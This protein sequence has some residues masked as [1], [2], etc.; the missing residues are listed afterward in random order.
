RKIALRQILTPE[1]RARLT[2]LKMV[3]PEL[4]TR[5]EDYLIQL[6]QAGRIRTPVTDEQLKRLLAALAARKRNI[7]IRRI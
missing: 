7:R 3:R 2:N 1:A 4:A 5:V 6:A